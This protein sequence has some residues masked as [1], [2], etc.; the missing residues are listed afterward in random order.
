MP[1]V[2]DR[3]PDLLTCSPARYHC[4]TADPL[5]YMVMRVSSII[6]LCNKSCDAPES[7][8]KS[9]ARIINQTSRLNVHILVFPLAETVGIKIFISLSLLGFR[10]TVSEYVACFS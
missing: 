1:Q 4:A 9:K 6:A 5:G 3:S 10:N 7:E 2:Q 8:E